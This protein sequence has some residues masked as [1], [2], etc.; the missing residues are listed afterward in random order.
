MKVKLILFTGKH[1]VK[2]LEKLII[3]QINFE[4]R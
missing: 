2:N 3:N 1:N 4:I